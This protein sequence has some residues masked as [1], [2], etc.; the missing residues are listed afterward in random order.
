[1]NT[2]CRSRPQ[3][4]Q[5]FLADLIELHLQSKQAHWNVVGKDFRDLHL[6]LDEPVDSQPCEA[7]LDKTPHR[8]DL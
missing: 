6:R 8:A 2:P 4:R 1:M 3:S 5:R 7:L